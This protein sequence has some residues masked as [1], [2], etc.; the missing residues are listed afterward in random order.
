MR[1][2]LVQLVGPLVALLLFAVAIA[3]LHHEL[4]AHSIHDIVAHLFAIPVSKLVT[5]FALT[6]ASYIVLTGYDALSLRYIGRAIPYR[7]IALGSFIAYAFAHNVGLS[8]LGGSAVRY[9]IFSHWGLSAGEIAREI[10]FNGVSF[11][12]GVCG[13]GGLVLTVFN[14]PLPEQLPLHAAPRIIGVVLLSVLLAYFV[15]STLRTKPLQIRDFEIPIP[16]PKFTLSQLVIGATDW[17]VASSVLYVLLPETATVSY[18]HVVGG[19]VLAQVVGVVSNV[20][21]GLGVFE[22]VVLF[23]LSPQVGADAMMGILIAYRIIYYLVP[24]LAGVTLL[25]LHEAY[26]HRREL[27]KAGAQAK[28]WSTAIIPRAMALAVFIAGVILLI[29]AALPGNVEHIEW[30]TGLTSLTLLEASHLVS[31]LVGAALLLVARGIRER[32]T[33]A[34]HITIWLL[35]IGIITSLLKGL[36]YH[37]AVLLGIVL[38]A[39][40]PCRPYFYRKSAL[41]T[42][43]LTSNWLVGIGL[44]IIGISGLLV[45]VHAEASFQFGSVLTFGPLDHAPRSIRAIICAFGGIILYLLL[46]FT[47]PAPQAGDPPNAEQLAGAQEVVARSKAAASHLALL[48]DK[49]FLFNNNGTAFVMFGAVGRSWI[50]MGDPVGPQD[51]HEELIWQFK[52]RSHRNGALS[53]FYEVTPENLPLYIDLGLRLHKLG[54]EARVPLEE[55]SLKGKK[56]SS[57]RQTV[58]RMQR[59]GCEFAILPVEDVSMSMDDLKT[60]S[61]AW[62]AAKNTR[63][64]RFSLGYFDPN[65]IAR[66]P[67]AV[68]RQQEKI[69]A[70]ANLWLSAEQEEVSIDLMRFVEEAPKGVME[71]LFTQIM[72]WGLSQGFRW[73]NLGMAPLAG[74]EQHP[75]APLWHRIG[76][77]LFQHG[78]HFYNF[79]GLRAYKAKFKPVWSPRYLASPGGLTLPLVLSQ[80][81]SLVSGGMSGVLR[82]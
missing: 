57:L 1:Y 18:W 3:V 25:S 42:Q 15:A 48:G 76:T 6:A 58:N 27:Y 5:A 23:L 78:E 51:D 24:F 50:A 62:L 44:V 36:N 69:V 66:T 54:E 70:F 19:F 17:L 16:S 30:L 65:Y 7:Q 12:V 28:L 43:P 68:I 49:Y 74:L 80:V 11:W 22:T 60:V 61:D 38:L 59:E 64:K 10:A 55:F 81:S 32:V 56:H 45:W 73:F 75:L 20:P 26:Q 53:A 63:E 8:S 14:I 13:L 52:E 41:F 77:L 4:R 33:G 21:G 71:Y 29:S 37:E 46:R 72:L 34:Y 9:R 67:V 35:A 2:R 40:V 79:Q 47:R 82:K 31:A 39:F